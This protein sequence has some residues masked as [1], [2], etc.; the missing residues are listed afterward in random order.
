[1]S[2]VQE[3]LME[4]VKLRRFK[5]VVGL[6]A[7]ER[8]D[9]VLEYALDQASRHE[10]SELHLLTVVPDDTHEATENARARLA[11]LAES[12]LETFGGAGR[13]VHLHVRPGDTCEQ[14]TELVH[15][16]EADLLVVGGTPRGERKPRLGPVAQHM[17]ENA[18]CVVLLVRIPDYLDHPLRDRQCPACVTVRAESD[19]ERWFCDEHTGGRTLN[20]VTLLSH[21]EPS[22]RGGL[23][24]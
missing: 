16:V 13:R 20:S 22:L 9:A 14:L 23:M 11:G 21:S 5:V 15:E 18:A 3:V 1:M 2:S 17:V 19:G 7:S 24:L 6:G 10:R 8:A 4:P 12:K